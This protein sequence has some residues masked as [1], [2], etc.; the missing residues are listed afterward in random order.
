[1]RGKTMKQMLVVGG[2]NVDLI[3]IPDK[4]L[5][6]RDSNP[7]KIYISFGGVGRNIAHN[8]TLAGAQVNLATVFGKD[9]LGR[10]CYDDC[11]KNGISME[12]SR[13]CDSLGTSTYMAVLDRDRD[14]QV[15]INDMDIL[16]ELDADRIKTVVQSLDKEDICVLDT[17]LNARTLEI[18]SRDG[19]CLFAL[20][21]ISTH[22]AV[23]AKDIL[24][25]FDIVKP[26]F[27]QAEVLLG[28]KIDTDEKIL[29]ALRRFLEIGIKEIIIS[30]G[31][32][33]IA[34]TNGKEFVKMKMEAEHIVNATGA[35]DCLLACY[36]AERLRNDDFIACLEYALAASVMTI[37]SAE[38]VN[39][40]LNDA[41]IHEFLKYHDVE[42]SHL[43]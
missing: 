39:P 32:Q 31:E 16:D 34:A 36:L 4:S 6:M 17:N 35:G 26:N 21:P 42:R 19:V 38:T 1:M 27:Q 5:R 22:K 43:E 20:D 28:F 24:H 40:H 12:H 7:G 18:L 29:E 41:S 13:F 30:L 33:G 10:S 37:G 15:G 11:V 2:A 14:M 25:R 9:L 8:A 23:K 3:G